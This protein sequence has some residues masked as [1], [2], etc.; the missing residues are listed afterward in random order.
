MDDTIIDHSLTCRRALARLRRAEPALQGPPLDVLWHDYTHLLESVQADVF[1]GR[2]SVQEARIERFRLLT[3]RYGGPGAS[4][5]ECAELSHRYRATYQSLRRMVPGARAVLERLRGRTVI[6]VVT[7]NVVTEQEEK[8]DHF[9]LRRLIDFM[10]V[11]AGV[12][13][14][15][16]EP[17]IFRIALERADA[18]P[19]EAVMVGDSWRSDIAGARGVG[20]RPVW[21]NRFHLPPPDPWPVP[22]VD[23]FR[24]P[25][26]LEALLAGESPGSASGA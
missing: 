8:L 1:A 7:N 21:F 3:R 25:A 12:G 26:R 4:P 16:P 13:V 17:G 18:R 20:I 15:K 5:A 24:S 2:V 11:S 14:S 23:S 9:D 6:G 22:Q 10:V 19:E